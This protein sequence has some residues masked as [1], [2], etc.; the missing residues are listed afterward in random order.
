MKAPK[1]V[2]TLIDE[3]NNKASEKAAN[4][5][6]DDKSDTKKENLDQNKK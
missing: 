5:P 4:N 3:N 2:S 1:P 6:K